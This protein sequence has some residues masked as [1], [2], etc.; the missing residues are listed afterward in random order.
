MHLSLGLIVQPFSVHSAQIQQPCAFYVDAEVPYRGCA[1]FFWFDKQIP[2]NVALTSQRLAA[3]NNMLHCFGL[4]PA[5]SAGWIAIKQA[6]G[7]QVPSYRRMSRED[8]N[9][10]SQEMPAQLM[11]VVGSFLTWFAYEKRTMSMTWQISP[12]SMVLILS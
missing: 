7:I 12:G 10:Q 2:K 1:Y 6:Q 9:S 5:E 11:Q 4:L 8:G 3:A